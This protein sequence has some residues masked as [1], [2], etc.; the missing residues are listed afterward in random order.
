MHQNKGHS[1]T[2]AQVHITFTAY[3][4]HRLESTYETTG[5]KHIAERKLEYR[6]QF[7]KITKIPEYYTYHMFLRQSAS[8]KVQRKFELAMKN[9]FLLFSYCN[10]I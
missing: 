1:I 6:L 7:I 3:K 10:K 9:I 5:C 2:S 8:R 4:S